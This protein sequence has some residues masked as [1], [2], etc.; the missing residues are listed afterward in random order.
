MVVVRVV[1]QWSDELKSAL[2]SPE[3]AHS[4]SFDCI[5]PSSNPYQEF[6]QTYNDGHPARLQSEK[7]R[8]VPNSCPIP[9]ERLSNGTR[10]YRKFFEISNP[11]LP[12]S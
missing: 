8:P 11:Y 3:T 9:V 10:P 5:L 2:H 4:L 1:V 7:S 12:S 6:E